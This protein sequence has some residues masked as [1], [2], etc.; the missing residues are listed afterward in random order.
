[1][2]K[3]TSLYLKAGRELR[4]ILLA[5]VGFN[6]NKDFFVLNSDE[7]SVLSG[8]MK[9]DGYH[10]DSPQGRS[11]LRSYYYSL[12]RIYSKVAGSK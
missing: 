2:K 8:C 7:L 9:A 4:V 3:K 11:R 10:Y 1:M 6:L 5:N 12:Q